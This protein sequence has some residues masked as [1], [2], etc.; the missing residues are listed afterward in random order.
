VALEPAVTSAPADAVREGGA[1]SGQWAFG[2]DVILLTTARI[3]GV[4]AGFLTSVLVARVLGP[5]EL[6]AAAVALTIGTVAALVANGGLNIAG[7]YYLG[8]RPD[9]RRVVVHRT[10][11]L[12]LGASGLA[13]LLVILVAW[14]AGQDL[15]STGGRWIVASAAALGASIVGYELTSS[16]V[17]GLGLRRAYVVTQV[18]E[19]VGSFALVA[20]VLALV[21]STG[22]GYVLGAALA[23]FAA[24][25]YATAVARRDVGGRMLAFDARFARGA[26]AFGLR[27]QVGNVLQ[28]LNLRLDLLLVPLLVDLRAAGI[29]LIAVRMSEVVTQLASAASALL[30]QEV[31]RTAES[32]SALTERT[33]RTTLLIVIGSGAAIALLAVLLLDILFGPEFVEGAVALRIT[34][35]AMIPLAVTRM[36]SGDLKGRGRPGLVSIAAGLALIATVIFDLA[37]IP[38]LGIEGAAIASLLAYSIGAAA[39]IAGFTRVTG[40]SP[41]RLVPGRSDVTTLVSVWRRALRSVARSRPKRA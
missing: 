35:T 2:R 9:E 12:G 17:L 31:A 30:F 16:L 3:G 5:T 32:R 22:A 37:L 10:F 4:G 34:M 40:S 25:V 26:L 13:A 15:A 7:I 27:G 36:L 19:G 24:A 33:V 6:G 20:L 14:P 28:F 1:P 18:I 11:T 38:P 29:Y 21:A 41:M 23:Y 8:R 39:M